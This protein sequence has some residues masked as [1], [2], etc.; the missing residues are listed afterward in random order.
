MLSLLVVSAYI[1][2]PTANIAFTLQILI[3]MIILLLLPFLDSLIILIV[4][5]VIGVIGLPVFSGGTSSITP[6]FGFVIGFI[7]ATIFVFLFKKLIKTKKP[8]INNIIYS[9]IA[10]I[11]IYCFG[12]LFFMFYMDVTF[13]SAITICVVP[14]IAFDIA[15]CIIAAI[16]SLKLEKIISSDDDK[17]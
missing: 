7:I 8:L 1:A 14:Y 16:T 13:L 15:K 4:Y 3:I 6:T 12:V 9:I 17:E 5:L 11:V 10:L 2:I